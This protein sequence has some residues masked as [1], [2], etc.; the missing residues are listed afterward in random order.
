MAD[1]FATLERIFGLH[2]LSKGL[3]FQEPTYATV[4][5][6]TLIGRHH[7]LLVNWDLSLTNKLHG[8][9]PHMA[10]QLSKLYRKARQQ[11]RL[12][13]FGAPTLPEHRWWG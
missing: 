3:T 1:C 7:Q 5:P 8:P 2:K 11:E 6:I 4:S 9:D 12:D 10:P 13:H